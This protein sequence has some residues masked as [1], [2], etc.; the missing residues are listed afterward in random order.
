MSRLI[1]LPGFGETESIFS[2]IAPAFAEEQLFL[3]SW[4]LPGDAPR[5]N[6]NVLDFAGELADKYKITSQD[7][8]IGHSMGGWIGLHLKQITGCRLVQIASWTHP[9]R[10]VSPVKNPDHVYWL[11]RKGLYLNGLLQWVFVQRS[12]RKAPSRTVFEE[13]F[14][15]LRRGNKENIV[16]Q[17][18]LIMEP[19]KPV[20]VAPDLR[21]HARKD[22][23]ILPPREDFYEVPGDHFT[24]VTHPET[25]VKIMLNGE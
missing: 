17:L 1:F 9:D 2:K 8:I 10:V 15:N 12:Y 23:I 7:S 20:G 16:N 6:L 3:N 11:V 22:S 14:G 18:R 19:V 25:V 24:L 4:H 13:V 5:P 21:I